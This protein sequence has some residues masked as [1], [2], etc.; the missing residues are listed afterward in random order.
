MARLVGKETSVIVGLIRNPV[1][2]TVM[3]LTYVV[4]TRGKRVYVMPK[5]IP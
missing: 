1:K 2:N 5:E 4:R 3:F